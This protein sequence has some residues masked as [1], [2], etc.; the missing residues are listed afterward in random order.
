MCPTCGSKKHL[1][2]DNT[3]EGCNRCGYLGNFGGIVRHGTDENIAEFD[4]KEKDAL[5]KVR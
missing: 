2:D 4:K 3:W 1:W 5:P